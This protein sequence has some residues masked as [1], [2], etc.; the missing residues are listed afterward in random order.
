VSVSEFG[1]VEAVRGFLRSWWVVLP[2]RERAVSWPVVKAV[3]G[4][5]PV[6]SVDLPVKTAG[7]QCGRCPLPGEIWGFFGAVVVGSG[8]CGRRGSRRCGA[9]D[10]VLGHGCFWGP[11][12][13]FWATHAFLGH[14]CFFGPR[15][16]FG[17]T[18]VFLGH[19]LTRMDTDG[20]GWI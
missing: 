2:C 8:V 14:A 17:A 18:H 13:L 16:L 15:M 4:W 3:R 19:G 11:R 5:G 7:T 20:H 9:T 1:A 6:L 10:V 12:M